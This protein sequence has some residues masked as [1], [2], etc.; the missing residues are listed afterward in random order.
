M[1]RTLKE[2]LIE[3]I[4]GTE[5]FEMAHSRQNA[6]DV[7]RGLQFE[8]SEHF[9]KVMLFPDSRDLNHWKTELSTWL[10]RINRTRIKP[11]NK[12]LKYEDYF[13]LLYDEPLGH[14]TAIK[15]ILSDIRYQYNE[16][17]DSLDVDEN[18]LK[19]MYEELCEDLS[20]DKYE[21]LDYYLE[22]LK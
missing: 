2:M 20:I 11:N 9:I 18:K 15:D 6:L 19:L 14:P 16:Y 17:K 8:L 10:T 5:L 22:M 13:D 4:M 3:A 7:V 1:K 21:G 12:K